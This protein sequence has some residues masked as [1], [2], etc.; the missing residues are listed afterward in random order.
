MGKWWFYLFVLIVCVSCRESRLDTEKDGAEVL[1]S[2]YPWAQ[3][4]ISHLQKGDIIVK[5]NINILPGSSVL[6][7]GWGYGHAAIVSLGGVHECADSLLAGS[8]LI[9]STS[10]P[11]ASQY[12]VR[13]VPGF[14]LSDNPAL[15][16]DSFGPRFTGNRYRLRLPVEEEQIDSIIAFVRGQKGSLSSWNAMK[17][18][19]E[20][21]DPQLLAGE[22][23]NWADNSHWYCSL[24]IWQAVLYVTGMDLDVNGGFYVYPNDLINS[25]VFDNS[26][27][28]VGRAVF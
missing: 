4:G 12:Q 3:Q 8:M 2:A 1:G 17:R 5:P 16:N 11:I 28:F 7:G 26:E 27:E 15:H 23:Q 21:V 24:L 14:V 22:R 18:F 25:P 20:T 13:E 19:P 10:R 9:E 6:T